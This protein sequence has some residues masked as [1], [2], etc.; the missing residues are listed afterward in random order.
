MP[1]TEGAAT[2]K[3]AEEAIKPFAPVEQPD[4]ISHWIFST[5]I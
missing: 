3:I 5:G 1:L 2:R 4:E